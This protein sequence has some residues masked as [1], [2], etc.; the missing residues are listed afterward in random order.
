MLWQ[1]PS[2]QA[3]TAQIFFGIYQSLI[4]NCCM[5]LVQRFYIIRLVFRLSLCFILTVA[6]HWNDP[7]DRWLPGEEAWRCECALYSLAHAGLPG[8]CRS[9]GLLLEITVDG[10][11]V[12]SVCRCWFIGMMSNSLNDRLWGLKVWGHTENQRFKIQFRP[13]NKVLVLRYWFF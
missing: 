4:W 2:T 12:E 3:N 5:L 11:P 1:T 10:L 7:G 13:R 8:A 6:P 9:A